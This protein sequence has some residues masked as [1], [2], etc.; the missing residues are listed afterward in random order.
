MNAKHICSS[1]GAVLP[2]NAPSGL[3]VPCLLKNALPPTELP[4]KPGGSPQPT[5]HIA[6]LISASE[7]P[8]DRIGRYKLLQEIGEGGMGTVWMAEQ[9]E[10]VRRRIALKVIKLGMD[11]KQVI[12]RFEAE[13]QALAMMDHPNIA[14]VLDAGATDNGRPFFVMELVKG[15]P[16]TKYC[17]DNK[18]GTKERLELFIEVCRAI[19][20]AHQ[21]GIIHRDIKPSNILIANHDGTPVPKVIDFGIAKATTDQK[22]TDKTVFT[23][24]EQFIGTPAYMSPEQAEMNALDIDTRTDVYSLGVLLYELLTGKTPFDAK[25]LISAGLEGMRKMIREKEPARPSTRISSLENVEQTTVATQRHSE[26]PKLVHLVRGDLDWVAMKCLEKDRTRRYETAN[27]LAADIERHLKNEPV[28][29]CPPSNVYRLQKFVR[30]NKLAFA[31]GCAVI[32]ALVLGLGLATWQFIK[33]RQAR[34]LAVAAQNQSKE[35]ATKSQQVAQFLKDMLQGVGP[36]VALGRD[37]EL[38]REIVDQANERVGKDLTNQPVVQAELLFTI[39]NLYDE[40]ADYAKAEMALRESLRLRKS[41]FG[42]TN[43][44]VADSLS[45]LANAV[46]SATNSEAMH[47][48]A[49]AMRKFLF[50]EEHPDI[51]ISLH[52]LAYTLQLQRKVAGKSVEAEK[53]YREALAMRRKLVGNE[54]REVAQ[55]LCDLGILLWRN[56]ALPEA[57]A[58]Q[59]EAL[60]IRR[61]LFGENHPEVAESLNSLGIVLFAEGRLADSEALH[62]ESLA[63]RKTMLSSD[64]PGLRV[65]LEHLGS[66]L[67][68]QG[69]NEEAESVFREQLAIARKRSGDESHAVAKVL[70][71]IGVICQWQAKFQD[72]ETAHREALAIRRKLLGDTAP[73]VADSA[74]HLAIVLILVNRAAEAERLL[75]EYLPLLEKKLPDDWHTF[76]ARSLLG[77]SLYEQKDFKGAEPLLASGYEG[78]RQ[79]ESKVPAEFKREVIASFDA[80]MRFYKTTGQMDKATNLFVKT[81]AENDA[82]AQGNIGWRYEKGTG[83]RK[84]IVEAIRWYRSAAERG[85]SFAHSRLISIYSSGVGVDKN[86][87]EARAWR[88]KAAEK[89]DANTLNGLAWELATA[90]NP[91]LRDGSNAVVLAERAVKMTGRT[92]DANL[93]TLA[94]A[95]AEARDFIKAAAAQNEAISLLT[96]E[97]AIKSF[98]SR[99]SLYESGQPYHEPTITEQGFTEKYSY[100]TGYFSKMADKENWKEQGPDGVAFSFVEIKRDGGTIVIKDPSRN[101]LLQLPTIG[102]MAKWSTDDGLSWND[103]FEVRKEEL[104]K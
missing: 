31:A 30:R 37:T 36:S 64:H 103:L 43:V 19:Q 28:V 26:P 79:R 85:S 50:G 8:G 90:S 34:E 74:N 72:A 42:P 45:S 65:T 99:L 76:K 60:A 92:N 12:G 9:E 80:L 27:G 100:A 104:S 93:D 84:D 44:M 77:E 21:K 52:D 57:E 55:T 22:L 7:K 32:A 86:I 94:A 5:I 4:A 35:D 20:H 61:N 97:A 38:L 1:C 101:M 51:A 17:D 56:N 24:F 67:W 41:I 29:A 2:P 68:Y 15:I 87:A 78:L 73:D 49:L 96:N 6:S 89:G 23:A 95:Y 102:G 62:R 40:L 71:W 88:I 11:T 81:A 70:N 58:A 83:P 69:K 48:E 10:P 47:R 46:R 59:R 3:C 75:N 98:K 18:V 14:K 63:I 54:D 82:G 53:L 16:I 13:R 33:E 91:D 66:M 39:G 25:D